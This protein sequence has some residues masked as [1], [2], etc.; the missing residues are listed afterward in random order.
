MY[1]PTGKIFGI[2]SCDFSTL[3]F[4]AAQSLSR[5]SSAHAAALTLP[6]VFCYYPRLSISGRQAVLVFPE[7]RRCPADAY[8]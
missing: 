5:T 3:H 7:L 2:Q 6:L 4:L 8:V 1:Q